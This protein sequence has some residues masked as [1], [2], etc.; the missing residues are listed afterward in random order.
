MEPTRAN[1][2]TLLRMVRR[3]VSLSNQARGSLGGILSGRECIKFTMNLRGKIC[4][5]ILNK[6]YLYGTCA[7]HFCKVNDLIGIKAPYKHGI[8]FYNRESCSHYLFYTP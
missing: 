3:M 6:P 1:P 2:S 8:D 7:G 5:H 4:G